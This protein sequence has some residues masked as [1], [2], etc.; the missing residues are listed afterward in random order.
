MDEELL[1]DD[2]VAPSGVRVNMLLCDSAQAVGG[3]LFVLGGGLSVMGPRPQPLAIAIHVTVPWDRGNV[4]HD[5]RIDLVDEDGRP[6]MVND[7]PIAVRGQFEA[8]R[9]SGLRAGTPLGVALAI[10][11][12]ALRLRPGVGYSFV[13]TVAGE[14]RAEWRSQ[15][16]VKDA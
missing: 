2:L 9:P 3:K 7:K 10:N 12:T 11:L 16:F 13:F 1:P 5:W 14:S 4:K 8:G 15:L 6:V